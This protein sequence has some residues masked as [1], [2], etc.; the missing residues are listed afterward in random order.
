M[1]VSITREQWRFVALLFASAVLLRVVFRDELLGDALVALR[2]ATAEVSAALIRTVG[3]EAV[4]VGATVHHPSGFAMEITRG[5][6]GLVGATLLAVAI[7][8]YPA[9][10]RHGVLGAAIAVP[11]LVSLNFARLVHLYVL[12]LHHPDRFHLAH[13]VFWQGGMVVTIFGLWLG[14]RLWAES[15]P[16]A[17]ASSVDQ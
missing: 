16:R 12:G 17:P 6:T 9:P 4:R 11:A 10:P 7:I 15:R 8:A 2:V 1:R 5:C 3:V 14:W 13:E